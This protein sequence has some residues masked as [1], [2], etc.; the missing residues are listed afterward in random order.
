[1]FHYVHGNSREAFAV[2]QSCLIADQNFL[3][4][5]FVLP[6]LPELPEELE[7]EPLLVPELPELL[8]EPLKISLKNP[9]AFVLLLPRALLLL[10]RAGL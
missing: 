1:M 5:A 7:L 3:A 2:R 4:G 6:E 8:P 10:L 9:P